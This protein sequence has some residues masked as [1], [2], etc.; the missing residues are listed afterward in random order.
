MTLMAE[1][2]FQRVVKVTRLVQQ[3]VQIA[4]ALR[5]RDLIVFAMRVRIDALKRDS[6]LTAVGI[7]FA[8]R[9]MLMSYGHT[10]GQCLVERRQVRQQA[11]CHRVASVGDMDSLGRQ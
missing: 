9:Q 7:P 11:S 4:A 2:Y 6:R 10:Y 3:P 5:L 1:G 8:R